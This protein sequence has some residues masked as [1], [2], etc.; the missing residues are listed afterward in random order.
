MGDDSDEQLEQRVAQ[1]EEWASK[2][3]PG[4]RGVLKGL[5]AAALGGAA[6][7]GAT[8]GA[9]G[10]SA[11][12]QIGTESEPVDVEAASVGAQSVSTAKA[13][14][15]ANDVWSVP[16][17]DAPLQIVGSTD[18]YGIQLQPQN[19][20]DDTGPGRANI[21]WITAGEATGTP[22]RGAV[23]AWH[24]SDNTLHAYTKADP[25]GSGNTAL[26]KRL[27]IGG[28]ATDVTVSWKGIDK[29]NYS[30]S[31]S[32]VQVDYQ[33]GTA[34]SDT[35]LRFQDETGANRWLVQHY[36]SDAGQLRFR[37]PVNGRDVFELVPGGNP[38]TRANRHNLV[39]QSGTTFYRAQAS[40]ATGDVGVRFADENDTAAA[41]VF[42]DR[43]K[44]VLR[45]FN[46][47]QTASMMEMDLTDHTTTLFDTT[48]TAT[49]R[50]DPNGDLILSGSVTENGSP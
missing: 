46:D 7:S 34:T 36:N 18:G 38:I 24:P 47:E 19:D 41:S 28:G 45:F 12:G 37:D 9:S 22:E 33:P 5:G 42:W 11:A 27:D 1:L 35:T 48:G 3:F 40:S 31:E 49:A 32:D 2:S 50:F 30:A 10:Q 13:L 44:D 20:T 6:V 4:R 21:G 17:R 26:A 43:S 39:G 16:D 25:V 29:V 23:L 15:D 14:L 8:G